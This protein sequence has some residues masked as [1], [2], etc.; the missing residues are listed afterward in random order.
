MKTFKRT[1]ALFA[2]ALAVSISFG[3]VSPGTLPNGAQAVQ[4]APQ[5][6]YQ[7]ES[8]YAAAL[9]VAVA[10]KRLPTCGGAFL[11]CS[12]SEIVAK[13]QQADDVAIPLLDAAQKVART[14]GAG[15]NLQTAIDAANAAVQALTSITSTLQVQ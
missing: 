8:S 11:I 4:T 3:C 10:Y 14:P 1:L 2:I 12:K 9:T 15:M 5:T 13:L 6:I 7:V